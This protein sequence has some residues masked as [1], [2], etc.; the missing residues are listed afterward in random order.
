EVVEKLI[1]P[2][3]ANGSI[4]ICDRFIDST[5][6]YQ[7]YGRTLKNPENEVEIHGKGV[8][9]VEDLNEKATG[10]V[11]P[12]LTILV[13]IDPKIGLKRAFN[14]IEERAEKSEKKEDRFEKESLE[15]HMRVRHGFLETAEKNKDR[16]EIVDGRGE[17]SVIHRTICDIIKELFLR[18]NKGSNS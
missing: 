6:A 14:K 2:A 11:I 3:L 8:G 1:R 9:I 15:F 12:D 18:Q 13:D 17:I 16:F 7:G 5:V 10:G 4:V